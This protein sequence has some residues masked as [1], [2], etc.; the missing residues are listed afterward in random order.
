MWMLISKLL[1][2]TWPWWVTVS[3]G[4]SMDVTCKIHL[5]YLAVQLP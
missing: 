5:G 4:K 1:G 3:S 2:K